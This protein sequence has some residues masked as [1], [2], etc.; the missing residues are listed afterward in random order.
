MTNTIDDFQSGA[1]E[2]AS[3]VA[4]YL[5]PSRY[6]SLGSYTSRHLVYAIKQ[7]EEIHTDEVNTLLSQTSLNKKSDQLSLEELLADKH[8]STDDSHRIQELYANPSIRKLYFSEYK[9]REE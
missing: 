8:I 6:K 4:K 9:K 5:T 2:L 3:L 1:V 7:G